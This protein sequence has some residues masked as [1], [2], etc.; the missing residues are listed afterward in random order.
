MRTILL[1]LVCVCCNVMA[2]LLLRTGASENGQGILSNVLDL[3]AWASVL[4]SLPVLGGIALWTVSTLAWIYLLAQVELSYAFALYSLNYL[5]T[6]LAAR[7]YLQESMNSLQM[8]GM[9][10]ITLGVGVSISA[11]HLQS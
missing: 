5:F 2:Q 6:P 9:A 1:V 8:V 7:W 11:K 10:I 3:K 4:G